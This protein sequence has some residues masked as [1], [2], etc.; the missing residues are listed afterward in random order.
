MVTNEVGLGLVP[1]DPVGRRF[2]EVLGRVNQALAASASEV[3]LMMAGLPLRV[4][5][6]P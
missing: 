6:R 1:M 3:A 4:K 2:R 5:G